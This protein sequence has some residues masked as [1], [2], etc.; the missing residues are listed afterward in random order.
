MDRLE[1]NKWIGG[2]RKYEVQSVSSR[3]R[4]EV[5]MLFKVERIKN[6]V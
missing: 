6:V 3:V 1:V 2:K 4:R 5:G